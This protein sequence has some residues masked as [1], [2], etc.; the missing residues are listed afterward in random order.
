M[1]GAAGI[2]IISVF[3]LA[4]LFDATITEAFVCYNNNFD[5]A[6]RKG[7]IQKGGFSAIHFVSLRQSIYISGSCSSP[8]VA[9]TG[10][11]RTASDAAGASACLK[12]QSSNDDEHSAEINNKN[13]YDN[14][15]RDDNNAMPTTAS[16][17]SLNSDEENNNNS[18]L[19]NLMKDTNELV[20]GDWIVAKRD[21]PSLGIRAGA[22]YQLVAM[23]LKGGS[24][25]SVGSVGGG[26]TNNDGAA[27]GL[28]VEVIP[29]QR[30]GDDEESDEYEGYRRSNAYTKYLK[31]YNPRDHEGTKIQS[32]GG[33]VVTPEE[34]GL[35]S[36][37]SYWTEALFLAVPGFFWVFVAMS[38]SNYYTDR[39]GGSFLDAFFR[40]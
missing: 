37:K 17:A 8:F 4:V 21:I 28:G 25:G 16:S 39:Y 6:S 24:V 12:A 7:Q 35:V 2:V 13:L 20:V 1:N 23:Y 10:I 36:V 40:T 26:I 14:D 15:D 19:N 11:I 29:L 30:Y 9:M 38:F 34:I 32:E 3:V 33:A 31:I 5:N 27:T 22:V 18:G